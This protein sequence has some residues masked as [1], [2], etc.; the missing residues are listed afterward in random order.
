MTSTLLEIA[1]LLAER[2][3]L[4]RLYRYINSLPDSPNRCFWLR[5]L[6]ALAN[7]NES[8]LN[9]VTSALYLSV[10]AA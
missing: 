9:I 7:T 8:R 10:E 5:R 6:V 2:E 3:Q 4:R 1:R